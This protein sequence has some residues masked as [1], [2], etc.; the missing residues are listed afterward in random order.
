LDIRLGEEDGVEILKQLLSLRDD[1]KVIMLTGYATIDSAV[2]S[3]KLGAFDYIQKPAKFTKLL[4]S[5]ENVFK[6]LE[7]KD[8]NEY[9]KDRIVQS[10][11]QIITQNKQMIELCSKA[12]RLANSELPV[13]ITGESGT[14]KEL[15]ADFIHNHS[16]KASKEL[17]KI[18]CAS[19]PESL[20]D[21]ELF[22]HEKG[23][24]TGAHSTYKGVF[25]VAHESTLFLDEIGDMPF[26]LQAKILRAIQNKQIRR[27]GGE[28]T[29][30]IE[31]RF[32]A[33]TNKNLSLLVETK[34]FR[35]DLFYRLNAAILHIPP[36]RERKEDIPLL[37]DYFLGDLNKSLKN[38]K[39]ITD[40]VMEL[41]YEYGWPGN[42]RELKNIVSYLHTISLSEYINVQD[43]PPIFISKSEIDVKPALKPEIDKNLILKALKATNYN[44]KKTADMLNI[45]RKTL[46]NRMERYGIQTAK[47]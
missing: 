43:L 40:E 31:L 27:I 34:N 29:I 12:K 11:S 18:N 47:S 41:F 42:V 10:F 4:N 8:Q 44:K 30:N 13:L 36:L 38:P 6:L 25:E 7:L 23:A 28:S 16:S 9:L 32:I 26:S 5:I 46:Y 3:I 39:L 17:V 19:F 37:A 35:E 22:G 21:N 2:E 15:V 14:G 45:C 33:A 20:L 24:F 1:I